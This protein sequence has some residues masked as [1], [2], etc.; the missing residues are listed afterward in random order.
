M[1]VLL[2][3]SAAEIFNVDFNTG[4][5][6]DRVSGTLPTNTG[7]EFTRQEKGLAGRFGATDDLDGYG[8]VSGVKTIALIIRP[9]ADT[10]LIQD[11]GTDILEITGGSFSGTGLTATYV[12]N[13][14]SA[15][16]LLDRWQLVI[17]EFSAGIDISTDL[18]IDV[19]AGID[20]A[21]VWAVDALY[22]AGERTSEYTAFQNRHHAVKTMTTNR[23]ANVAQFD[24]ASNYVDVGD[25]SAIYNSDELH[26]SFDFLPRSISSN[27]TLFSKWDFQTQGTIILQT[28]NTDGTKLQVFIATAIGDD[29]TGCSLEFS[30]NLVAG[31]WHHL[32]LSFF[33]SDVELLINGV[34]YPYTVLSGAIPSTLT[35]GDASMKIGRIGGSLTRYWQGD[36]KNVQLSTDTN[37]HRWPLDEGAGT[38]AYDSVGDNDG[39]YIGPQPHGQSYHNMIVS[40]DAT[41]MPADGQ[42]FTSGLI[43]LDLEVATGTFIR[44]EVA[45]GKQIRCTSNGTLKVY[46]VNLSE[47]IGNGYIQ[48]LGGSLS[49]DAG[50]TV[51]AASSVSFADNT[52]TITMT[53]GQTLTNFIIQKEATP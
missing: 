27:L 43:D 24:G 8:T 20:I 31:K 25:D 51:D 36:I 7:V 28:G 44:E 5:F 37:K 9:T 23:L 34:A 10:K 17:C 33:D 16:A 19:T 50:G 3:V 40:W 48:S 12:N 32:Y 29:G 2:P 46:G 53:A 14:A 26:V 42:S 38:I 18:E 6:K 41:N 47:F 1:A 21:A 39:A 13:S 15:V 52:I 35:D 30:A 4:S 49:A 11:D 45:G 22:T